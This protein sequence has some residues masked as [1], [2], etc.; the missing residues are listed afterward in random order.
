MYHRFRYLILIPLL[1][2]FFSGCTS[3]ENKTGEN[4]TTGVLDEAAE[5]NLREILNGVM[6]N[7]GK[8]SDSVSLY[9]PALLSA[10]YNAR[11]DKQVWTAKKKFQPM[12]DTLHEFIKES[13]RYGLFPEDYHLSK[14]ENI[15]K[16]IIADSSIKENKNTLLAR[17]E[18][19][20][21]DAFF[22]IAEHLK[23][24]RLSKDSI[25]LSA[26]STLADN[27]YSTVL[28]KAIE[29]K[30]IKN[31][32]EELEPKH[33]GYQSLKA[34]LPS[35]LQTMD[36]HKYTYVVYPNKDSLQL[37]RSVMRRL[38]EA[39]ITDNASARPDSSVYIAAVIRYQKSKGIKPTGKINAETVRNMNTSDW[40]RFKRLAATLDRYKTLPRQL[41]KT[42]I[43][44]NLPG[45][46][47]RVMD[48]DS[49]VMESKVIVGK[50]AN[51]TPVLNSEI[52]N[53]VLWPTWSVPYSIATK[54]MLPIAKRNPGYFERR[55]FKVFDWRGRKVNPYS[56]NWNKYTGRSLPYRF[57]QNEGGGN[58][59]GVIKFNFENPYA[60]YLH[61]TNQ[62]YLFSRSSRA[63]SH[64]CVRVQLWDSMAKFLIRRTKPYMPVY[65]TFSRD[66]I[67]PAGDTIHISK[68][69][70]KDSVFI[71]A[72]SL[73]SIMAKRRNM[74]L[75]MP[76]KIPIFIRYFGCEAIAGKVV[77]YEDI[78]NEDKTLIDK[79]FAKK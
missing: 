19:L 20:Y 58:A 76:E 69:I 61:D 64:G 43:W 56:V 46:Y 18:L 6:S 45:Y 28:K 21:S 36:L 38:N 49:M 73:K 30:S 40:Y 29:E 70:L 50:P 25:S 17:A 54:E 53:M 27:F 60:V 75:M 32:F 63:M 22:R 33:G 65:E 71:I 51:R 52:S 10:F 41:P 14:L 39:G 16:K 23:K 2:F 3:K 24:G 5:L 74:A 62:R 78:Y 37:V 67:V 26:D 4:T 47:V 9:Y 12:A 1:L 11:N 31:I 48:K 59:L 8:F 55:G 15:H 13:M 77:F 35:F 44:V 7:K 72:D 68:T 57:Q 42:Y 66:S 79:F 34:A